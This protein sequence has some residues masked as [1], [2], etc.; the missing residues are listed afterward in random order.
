MKKKIIITV[1]LVASLVC[2]FALCASATTRVFV[3]EASGE[4]IFRVVIAKGDYPITEY[5][6][7][8]FD[9]YDSDGDALAWYYIK[10]TEISSGVFQYTVKSEKTKDL[11]TDDGDGILKS[12]EIKNY[13]RLV[14]ITFGEDLEI[15]E[16]ASK[17]FHKTSG[18]H[19]FLFVNVPDSV[20]KLGDNCF[21]NC[22][23]LLE[24]EISE[25][26][27]LTDLGAA[28]FFGCTSLR[29]IYIPKGVTT[30]KTEYTNERYWENGLFRNCQK[31]GSVIFDENSE[32]EVLEKGTFNYCY[33][34]KTITLPN[35]VKTVHPRV[36]AQCTELEYVNFGGG[37]ERIVRDYA[38]GDEYVSLFQY[39]NK[40]KTVVLPASFKAENLTDDLHTT[41]MISGITVYYSG[42]QEEFIELQK[43][44]AKASVGSGN[45]GIINAT[46]NYISPCEAFYNGEHNNKTVITYSSYDVAGEKFEGCIN[47][48]CR[49]N[50]VTVAPALITVKGE[51]VPEYEFSGITVGYYVNN[52]AIKDYEA[53]MGVDIQYGVFAV[54][55]DRLME[56]DVFDSKANASSGVIAAEISSHEF[57][58]F[59]L[60]ITGFNEAQ[61]DVKIAMGAFVREIS[62]DEI[63]HAYFQKT[64]PTDGEKYS[65]ICY[66]D[67]K[68]KQ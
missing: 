39:T 4:E 49:N 6:G 36:F 66:N 54:L 35:S 32:L 53:T 2:L 40:L 5:S 64:K 13:D 63:K 29:S 45:P 17:L 22:I 58:S 48:G 25:N 37:L 21:R 9:K 62:G 34:L 60:K 51:S 33:S 41:F 8:G 44:F 3:D 27:K 10:S 20:T 15:N 26:S 61:K 56:N 52:E 42:T 43:K 31:L 23:S 38:G 65:F 46:Y 14:A 47:E 68:P 7:T 24:V 18:Q 1:F 50:T 57:F 67:V 28:S 12:S 16:F 55:K 11:L 59:S 30:L 19:Y